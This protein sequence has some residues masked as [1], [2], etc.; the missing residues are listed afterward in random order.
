[1]PHRLCALALALALTLGSSAPAAAAGPPAPTANRLA[2]LAC[3]LAAAGVPLG[4]KAIRS[5]VDLNG[6]AV[7]TLAGGVTITITYLDLNGDHVF[8]CGEP[9]TSVTIQPPA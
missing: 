1:M 6:V 5:D 4:G 8:T 9:V 3:L 2:A 7:L